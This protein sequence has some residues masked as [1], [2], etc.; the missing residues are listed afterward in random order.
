MYPVFG[1]LNWITPYGLMLVVALFGGWFY[2]RRRALA[3]GMDVSHVDLAVPLIFAV[4]LLGAEILTTISPQDTEFAGSLV[5]S[6][7]RFRL[8]GLLLVAIPALYVYS[9]VAKL[10]FRKLID[11][12]ALPV[13]LWLALIRLGCF[14]AGCCWGDLIHEPPGL[15]DIADPLL[16]A[17]VL[18]LPWLSGTQ[19]AFG[20][21]FPTESL[22]YQQHLALGLIEPG[23]VSS[24]P[25]HPAQLYELILLIVLLAVLQRAES[26]QLPPGL[27]ALFGLAGYSVL[28]FLIEFL[29][30][31][32]MLVLGSLTFHQLSCIVLLIVCVIGIA[33]L[34]HAPARSSPLRNQG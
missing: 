3:S 9:R 1:S 25:V 14:M 23:A 16:S 12:S 6:H 4:S 10:S 21:S 5:Q 13:L 22:A 33:V 31:D 11:L 27:L 7:S 30:A 24:L 26:K 20:A 2:M 17:Q 19:L 15:T 34:K 18:T 32:N 8:F 29:R 28:R